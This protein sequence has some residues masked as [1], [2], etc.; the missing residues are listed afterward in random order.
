MSTHTVVT[1]V[2]TGEERRELESTL[3]R[4]YPFLF[5]GTLY[6]AT[7]REEFLYWYL[8]ARDF[9]RKILDPVALDL[10]RNSYFDHDHIPREI[11]CAACDY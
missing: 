5:G 11:L 3:R 6:D 4:E 9:R 2:P 10:E 1:V 8:R 7:A